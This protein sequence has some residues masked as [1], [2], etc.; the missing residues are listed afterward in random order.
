[1]HVAWKLLCLTPP[2]GPL[3]KNAIFPGQGSEICWLEFNLM[4]R[5]L[6]DD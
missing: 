4:A 6:F 3:L 2:E 1:M 5:V